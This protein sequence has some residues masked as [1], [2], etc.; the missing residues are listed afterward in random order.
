MDRLMWTRSMDFHASLNAFHK[1]PKLTGTDDLYQV[2][3]LIA[4]KWFTV[5]D[6]LCDL[7]TNHGDM[8]AEL[9]LVAFLTESFPLAAAILINMATACDK[10]TVGWRELYPNPLVFSAITERV[11]TLSKQ[12]TQL[13]QTKFSEEDKMIFEYVSGAGTISVTPVP[14]QR[15]S[16]DFEDLKLSLIRYDTFRTNALNALNPH[17]KELPSARVKDLT[18]MTKSIDVFNS[19]LV[20]PPKL[21]DRDYFT[22]LFNCIMKYNGQETY[23]TN[24]IRWLV[25]RRQDQQQQCLGLLFSYLHENIVGVVWH[26]QPLLVQTN[27]SLDADKRNGVALFRDWI[28]KHLLTDPLQ[29]V[30]EKLWIDQYLK[31]ATNI[32]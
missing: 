5:P 14:T 15:R 9:F 3:K 24:V 23:D 32:L 4:T 8:I 11:R 6:T 2:V 17:N 18:L 12:T 10:E 30:T 20:N 22:L 16:A 31:E 28:E 13:D 26:Y 21:A 25:N 7:T 29:Q 1:V 19:L 27:K